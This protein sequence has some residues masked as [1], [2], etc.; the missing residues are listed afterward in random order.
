MEEK[1]CFDK[2]N[3]DFN[4]IQ[5]M[6][7]STAIIKKYSFTNLSKKIKRLSAESQIVIQKI[8]FAV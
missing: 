7:I 4:K 3:I 5:S 2:K 8:C 1:I 6:K